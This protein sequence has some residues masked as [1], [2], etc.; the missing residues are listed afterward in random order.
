ML[1]FYLDYRVLLQVISTKK[2]QRQRLPDILDPRSF[3]TSRP[4]S[5]LLENAG[6]FPDL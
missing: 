2:K 5:H 4:S 1:E 6:Y 3:W